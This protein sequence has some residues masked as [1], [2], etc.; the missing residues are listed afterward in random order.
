MTFNQKDEE[1]VLKCHFFLATN[2]KQKLNIYIVI[3]F[4]YQSELHWIELMRLQMV[5]AL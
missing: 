4:K 3:I 5:N 1:R 2:F